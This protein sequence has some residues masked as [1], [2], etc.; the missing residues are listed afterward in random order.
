MNV[1]IGLLVF[2][3]YQRMV[4]LLASGSVD[5]TIRIWNVASGITIKTLTGH[6]GDV[7]SLV[8]LPDGLLASG[9]YNNTIRIWNFTTG[10]NIKTLYGHDNGI[11]SLI[12]DGLLISGSYDT[13]IR[14]WS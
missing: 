3:F 14:I 6:T 12:D 13:T 7:K 1:L 11:S 4:G 5:T 8:V 10:F 2:L 9:S